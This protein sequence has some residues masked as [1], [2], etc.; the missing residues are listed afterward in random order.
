MLAPAGRAEGGTLGGVEQEP[1]SRGEF[2]FAGSHVG[3]CQ[4]REVSR[5][6]HVEVSVVPGGILQGDFLRGVHAEFV[7]SPRLLHSSP[8]NVKG[9]LV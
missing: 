9:L 4:A 5:D 8:W 3:K 6:G 2:K 7:G 1:T